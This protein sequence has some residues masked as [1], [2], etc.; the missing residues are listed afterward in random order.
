MKQG[1]HKWTC[2]IN[3]YNNC[4]GWNISLGIIEASA[5]KKSKGDFENNVWYQWGSDGSCRNMTKN[6]NGF[7]M[8]VAGTRIDCVLDLT[9]GT[10]RMY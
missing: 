9:K 3:V 1:V 4:Y 8:W 7:S 10:F 5:R 2:I 6:K